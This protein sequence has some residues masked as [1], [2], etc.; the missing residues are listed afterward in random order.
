M[1]TL[2]DIVNEPTTTTDPATG[3][4]NTRFPGGSLT[5]FLNNTKWSGQSSR[6]YG[7]FLPVTLIGTTIAFSELPQEGHAELWELVNMTMDAHPIHMHLTD[8]QL[9]NRQAFDVEAYRR[10]Y[11][12]AFPGGAFLPGFGPPL[13]YTTGNPRALGGNPDVTPFL[14]G[15]EIPPN[16][17]ASG[18]KDASSSLPLDAPPASLSYPFDPSDWLGY[19]WHCH[20]TTHEDNEMMRS[21]RIRL[22]P[23]APPP[24]ERPLQ[25]GRDY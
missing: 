17:Y 18:W 16:A 9:V 7:D 2:N 6:P 15:G 1:L 21:F 13:D 8:V 5:L 24:S 4:A 12:S 25:Q 20:I 11:E 3:A 19:P 22:N 14:I 10:A 23:A